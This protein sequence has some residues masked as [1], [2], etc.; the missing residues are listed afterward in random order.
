VSKDKD[1]K[2]GK[3]ETS[4]IRR[5]QDLSSAFSYI[6]STRFSTNTG[7][8]SSSVR[9]VNPMEDL[10]KRVK[11]VSDAEAEQCDMVVCMPSDGDERFFDD[12]IDSTCAMCGIAIHHRPHVPKTPPKVCIHC[13]TFMAG[14]KEP[15]A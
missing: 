3:P 8:T 11:V 7:S 5:K 13:A 14:E 10:L 15:S 9:D 2:Q 4:G 1:K 12:D 6:D